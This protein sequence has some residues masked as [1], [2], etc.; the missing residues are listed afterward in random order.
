MEVQAIHRA[1]CSALLAM[2][3]K[4]GGIV[5][6]AFAHTCRNAAFGTDD[7]QHPDL[8]KVLAKWLFLHPLHL[9]S[10][11]ECLRSMGFVRGVRDCPMLTEAQVEQL[12]SACPEAVVLVEQRHG[13]EV[14]GRPFVFVW[15]WDSPLA[16]TEGK[17]QTASFFAGVCTSWLATRRHQYAAQFQS[18]VRV[19]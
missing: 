12:V 4:A 5:L 7:S 8:S 14:C 17:R 3:W 13:D 10:V 6:T 18:G 19:H 9:P 11:D 16:A 15:C 2:A 1:V